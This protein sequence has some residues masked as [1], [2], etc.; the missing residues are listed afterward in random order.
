MGNGGQVKKENKICAGGY[1]ASSSSK[2]RS[3]RDKL[4][5][6]KIGGPS[7]PFI[8]QNL[9]LQFPGEL[10]ASHA[11]SS[12]SPIYS[13]YI[14]SSPSYSIYP[15]I[16]ELEINQAIKNAENSYSVWKKMQKKIQEMACRFMAKS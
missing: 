5:Q 4:S 6:C 9:Q 13:H 1:V 8:D 16:N 7:K 15:Q 12:N 3:S 10:N 2:S 14:G 11:D